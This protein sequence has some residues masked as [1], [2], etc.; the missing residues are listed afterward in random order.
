VDVGALLQKPQGRFAI[1]GLRHPVAEPLQR[2]HRHLAY[3]RII[4]DDEDALETRMPASIGARDGAFG[5]GLP[6][7]SGEIQLDARSVT[8]LAVD[9]GMAAGLLDE[10]VDHAETQPGALADLLGREE[11]FE[12]P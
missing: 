8:D 9:L 5:S 1:R 2:G 10:A 12:D 4:L 6:G 3:R 11:R 7:R